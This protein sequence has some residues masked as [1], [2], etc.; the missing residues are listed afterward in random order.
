MAA[1]SLAQ[2][3]KEIKENGISHNEMMQNRA[4]MQEISQRLEA[5][6]GRRPTI[7]EIMAEV[8]W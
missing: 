3:V 6:L 7:V 1:K 8:W 4:R 5:Q 2:A